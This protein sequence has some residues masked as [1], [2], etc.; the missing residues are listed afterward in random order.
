MKDERTELLTAGNIAKELAVSDTKV[1][2]AIQELGL[3]PAAKK[4]VCNYYTRDMLNKIKS[5]VK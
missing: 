1:K 3:K 5:A 4:G 2:K